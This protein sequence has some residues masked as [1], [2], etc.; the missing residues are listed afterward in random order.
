M[1]NDVCSN[2]SDSTESRTRTGP[3][4]I[5]SRSHAPSVSL[6]HTPGIGRSFA[7]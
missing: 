5:C 2:I 4:A 3:A 1:L 6:I 7:S